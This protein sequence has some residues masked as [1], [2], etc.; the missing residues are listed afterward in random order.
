M[1]LVLSL[2]EPERSAGAGHPPKG[3]AV[4][5]DGA[6]GLGRFQHQRQTAAAIG[7][8]NDSPAAQ[9]VVFVAQHDDLPG[10]QRPRWDWRACSA[11]T[12]I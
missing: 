9:I 3:R 10:R 2:G 1:R 7:G 11:H 6:E 5:P 12:G 8:L 4:A